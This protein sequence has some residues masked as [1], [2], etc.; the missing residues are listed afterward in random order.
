MFV[1]VPLHWSVDWGHMQSWQQRR[2]W[3]NRWH[4]AK[5]TQIQTHTHM[6]AHTRRPIGGKFPALTERTRQAFA[7]QDVF[8]S[9]TLFGW[10]D[11]DV[12]SVPRPPRLP[13]TSH[14]AASGRGRSH[15]YGAAQ[16]N[17]PG[18]SLL[19]T[20]EAGRQ[21][22]RRASGAVTDC[23]TGSASRPSTKVTARQL[24]VIHH[25]FWEDGASRPNPSA[26]CII[27]AQRAF[28]NA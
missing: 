12:R 24:G 19:L 6:P 14:V 23:S 26:R 28:C 4:S 5:C 16:E 1:C 27:V 25:S 18:L 11:Q 21:G 8:C 10:R 17:R 7:Q 15:V 20:R 3:T 9:A 13:A 22:T 2:V